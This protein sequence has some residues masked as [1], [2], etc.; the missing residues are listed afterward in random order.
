VSLGNEAGESSFTY[1][2][3]YALRMLM[4]KRGHLRYRLLP[5]M[6][7]AYV[8]VQAPTLAGVFEEAAFAMFDVM[9]DPTAI[10]C[11]FVDQFEVT[12]HDEVSLFHDWLE[13][14]L[15]KFDLDGKVYSMFHVE[16]I[17]EKNGS[18]R[19]IAKAQGGMFERGRHPAKVEIKAVTYH[20]MEVT[21]TRNGYIARY[22]LDL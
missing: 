14:L 10:E 20:R 15:L 16:R 1:E 2:G 3:E 4:T 18:L 8:E 12:S 9:T 11:S 22:V 13:Q 21:A 19:L 6:T 17:E 7:D 5:H